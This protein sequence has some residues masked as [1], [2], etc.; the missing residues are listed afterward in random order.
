[1]AKKKSSAK[2]TKLVKKTSPKKAVKKAAPKK[3]PVVKKAAPKAAAKK[4][5]TPAKKA[6]KKVAP[7]AAAKKVAAKKTVAK[8]TV[9]K[10]AT[11]KPAAKKVV[12]AA[13]KA[14]AA[15]KTAVAK[16]ANQHLFRTPA[17]AKVLDLSNFVTPLDDRLIVQLSG[18]E[19][20]TAG[21]LYIPD[22]V[23]DVSGNLQG[24]VVAAGR[25]HISKKGHLRPMDVKV[26][27][28][29]VFAEYAGSK[30]KIQNEDL[31]IIREGDVMGVV[32]K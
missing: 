28:K 10:K 20:M 16:P 19:K 14:N 29:I 18:A 3:K 23:S 7:K 5:A 12:K 17:P 32:A 31:V 8:K 25:G 30:I 26:G 13:N 22:S 9:A 2:Q 11:V 27:D 1:M 21:G 6:A 15:A 4:K 24:T